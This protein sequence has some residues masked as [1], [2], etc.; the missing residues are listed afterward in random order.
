MYGMQLEQL[1][2]KG[3]TRA[4]EATATAVPTVEASA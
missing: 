2:I 1:N 3:E 4:E